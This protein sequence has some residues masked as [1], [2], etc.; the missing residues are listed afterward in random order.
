VA[1]FSF[2]SAHPQK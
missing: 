2:D 1:V